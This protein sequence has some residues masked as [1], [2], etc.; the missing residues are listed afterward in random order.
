[1]KRNKIITAVAIITV[2]LLGACKKESFEDLSTPLQPLLPNNL[3]TGPQMVDLKTAGRFGIFAA[4]AITNVGPS[5]ISNLDIG[6]TPNGR[7]SITGFSAATLVNGAIY[8]STDVTPDGTAAMLVQAKQD[9]NAAYLFVEAANSPIPTIVA[10]DQGGKTLL[11]GIYKS[12][13]SL[14]IQSGDLTL[15]AQGD[16][17]AIWYFQ[18]GSALT[19]IGGAGGNVILAGG[20]QAQNIFWQIG[21]S[22][23]IGDYTSFKGNVLAYS[24]VTLNSAAVVEGRVLAINA[25]VTLTSANT[26]SLE[27]VAVL[28]LAVPVP[29]AVPVVVTAIVPALGANVNPL[30]VDLKT[31]ERFGIFAAAA[32]TNVGATVIN[33]MDVGITP[34]GLTSITG[35]PPATIVNGAIYSAGDVS[36]SSAMLLQAKQDLTNAYLFAKA[37]VTPAPVLVAGDQGGKTLTPGIYK[38][39]SSLLIQSGNLTLD[40]Q[41][42]PNAVFI[43]QV[44]SALTTVGGAG[45][46]VILAGGAQA[47]NIF[48]QIGSSATI[49]DYT[50]FKGNVLAYTSITVNSYAVVEGR[51]LAINAAVTFASTN[52]LIRP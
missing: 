39:T 40:A 36:G 47:K 8:S 5:V 30:F 14:L 20:A 21:S 46:N 3:S 9:L 37:A 28:G 13:S 23:T 29:V 1:M 52:T 7:T 2:A 25:A 32:I 12:T 16:V 6:I 50:A 10:G 4:A 17:N 15:D 41:G 49:G 11:P 27:P 44:A 18:V 34:N 48:W 19:T 38:S 42:D 35:F 43:F 26:V 24:S 45:G 31:A 51:V 22:A 33:N